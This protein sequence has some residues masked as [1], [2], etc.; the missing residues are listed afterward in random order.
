MLEQPLPGTFAADLAPT[1]SGTARACWKTGTSAGQKDAW[2]FV[3]KSR[4]VV[5]VWMG[6]N[7]AHGSDWIVG[8]DVALPLAARLFRLM[9]AQD[10]AA[11]PEPGASLKQVEVCALSGLPPGPWCPETRSAWIPREQY[12]LRRCAVHYPAEGMHGDTLRIAERWPGSPRTW[13]LGVARGMRYAAL[14][15]AGAVKER[16]DE[17][18]ILHPADKSEY[19]LAGATAGDQVRLRT[20]VDQGERLDWYLDDRH[21]GTSGP[22]APLVMDLTPGQHRLACMS[23]GGAVDAVTFTAN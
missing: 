2:T 4:V 9:P 22:D 6:N 17:L 8:A 16:H 10:W 1:E 14:A 20:S 23:A 15:R 5:G 21:I 19:V 11:W 12:L 3:F 13:D 7:D 18:R